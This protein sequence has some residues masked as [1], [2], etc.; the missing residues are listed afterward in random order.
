MIIYLL[1]YLSYLQNGQNE[2]QALLASSFETERA[3]RVRLESQ[4]VTLQQ[5]QSARAQTE[6]DKRVVEQA[7]HEVLF[8]NWEILVTTLID[9]M[10]V[11]Y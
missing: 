7:A 11:I 1:W 9:L 3:A 5:Q 6:S 2:S 8:T 10:T 4:I